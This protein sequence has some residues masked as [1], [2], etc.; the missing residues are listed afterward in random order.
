M[1]GMPGAAARTCLYNPRLGVVP[2][3][4]ARFPQSS[5]RSAPPRRALIWKRYFTNGLHR[6]AERTDATADSTESTQTSM[7]IPLMTPVGGELFEHTKAMN[8]GSG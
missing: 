6:G 8:V 1:I 4:I 7:T 2:P 3:P 5:R